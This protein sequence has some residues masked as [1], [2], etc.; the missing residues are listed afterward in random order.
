MLLFGFARAQALLSNR[1]QPSRRATTPPLPM[2]APLRPRRVLAIKFYG[3]GNIALLLPVLGALRRGLPDAEIGFLTIE[4]NRELLERT[5]VVDNVHGVRVDS[6][7]ALVRS[8]WDVLRE[9]RARH[10]DV[11]VDFEQFVKLSTIVAFLSGARERIGFN[12]DGQRRGWLLTRRVVYTDSEHMTR[13]FMRVLRP[14]RV[15]TSVAP[16][17]VTVEPAEHKRVAEMLSEHGVAQ[18]H[19][20]CVA[21][22]VGSGPN[23]YEVP[24]KRW[25]MQHFAAVC[26]ALVERHGA[27]I[28]F[29]GRGADEAAIIREAIAS[30][31]H[32]AIDS[33]DQLSI[34]ELLALLQSCDFTLCNDTSIMH[35]SATMGTPVA[36]IFGPTNPL[37]YGPGGEGHVVIYKD[38]F[39]SPCLTNYNLKV[40]YCS[41][42]ICVRMIEP[43]EMLEKIETAFVGPHAPLRAG[44]LGRTSPPRRT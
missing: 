29:T 19:F 1:A 4:G 32:P 6:Y 14:L 38:L 20:P 28:I 36:A 22:H 30:M 7:G 23:F 9:I 37:Q 18:G 24:L 13:I 11:V 10:Y 34:G 17:S 21:V 2:E 40:S 16:V 27:A 25:P 3:L 44:A 31:K 8:F 26:D 12:T 43:D 41:D 33:C 35:L 39:C 5:D 42:P 15:D